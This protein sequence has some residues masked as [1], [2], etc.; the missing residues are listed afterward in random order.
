MTWFFLAWIDW[1]ESRKLIGILNAVRQ[2]CNAPYCHFS[3]LTAR[4][5]D[6]LPRVLGGRRRALPYFATFHAA[7]IVGT[8]SADGPMDFAVRDELL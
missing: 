1:L 4:R 8:G 7:I 5:S 3:P 6:H 2:D